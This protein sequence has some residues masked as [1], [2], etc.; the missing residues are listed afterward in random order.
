MVPDW[1]A[2]MP[3]CLAAASLRPISRV[4]SSSSSDGSLVPH[5]GR[6]WARAVAAMTAMKENL[7]CMVAYVRTKFPQD[8]D[9]I[10]EAID[11]RMMVSE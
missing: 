1:R 10:N 3:D 4:I 5:L 7:N 11:R 9:E 2:E 6:C 8:C